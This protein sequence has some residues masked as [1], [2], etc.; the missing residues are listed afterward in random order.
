MDLIRLLPTPSEQMP[1]EGAYLGLGLHR[2][3]GDGDILIYANY[4]AS[5]DGRIS[6]RDA[7]TGEFGVPASL[8]NGR[9]WRLYQELAA[10]AD[11]M[12][13]SARYM[14]QLAKGMAQDL[15]PVGQGEAYRD[16]LDWRAAEGL[17]AQ[18]DVVIVS[19]SLDIP[20]EALDR[21]TDRRVLVATAADADA[22][23]VSELETRGIEV[24]TAGEVQVEGRTL[25]RALIGRGYRG[26]Y[27]IAG[28]GVHRML[29]AD[30]ALDRL[31]LTTRHRLLGG[32]DFHTI[33]EADLPAPVR[34]MLQALYLDTE[35][36]QHFADYR[37]GTPLA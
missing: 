10:Q 35:G 30:G 13:V 19:T 31:F 5:L 1:L 6:L 36:E 25:R 33:V 18:P 12:I 27:M 7:A 26:A 2:Q 21:I 4:I 3:A 34:L 9:D 17:A 37:V 14:R 29:L 11:V 28:P 16:L 24:V 32:R 22:A 8:A 23:A 20:P 15:L